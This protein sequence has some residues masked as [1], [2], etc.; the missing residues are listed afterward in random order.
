[1]SR[2][3]SAPED[4]DRIDD[5]VRRAYEEFLNEDLPDR[6]VALLEKLRS[7]EIAEVDQDPT[8]EPE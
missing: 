4:I 8:D 1:M 5:I 2:E 3:E 6:F 7:G